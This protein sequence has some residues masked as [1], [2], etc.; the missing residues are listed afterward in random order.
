MQTVVHPTD[1]VVVYTAMESLVPF[2][3]KVAG[4]EFAVRPQVIRRLPQAFLEIGDV[5]C[6]EDDDPGE[7]VDEGRDDA[8]DAQRTRRVGYEPP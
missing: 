3:Q 8:A 7:Q 6:L 1:R 5:G 2:V 4:F